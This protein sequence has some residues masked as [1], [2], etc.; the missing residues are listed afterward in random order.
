MAID[1]SPDNELQWVKEGRVFTATGPGDLTTP[2]DIEADLVVTTP[3]LLVRVPAGVVIVPLRFTFAAEA[4]GAA[5]FQL[6]LRSCDNDPGTAN[7]T[8]CTVVNANTRY[9]TMGSKCT[10]YHTS[11][12]A[13]TTPT[14]TADLLR[15]YIQVD[16]NAVTGTAHYDQ[17]VY[18]PL[19]GRGVPCVIGKNGNGTAFL[20][21]I[22]NATSGDGYGIA[23]WAEFTYDE[24]YA[25]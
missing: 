11:T 16:I 3:D 1:L 18:S 8:A 6:L 19:Q 20:A 12:G 10:A 9:A 5:V 17:V 23:T 22:A 24:F 13:C 2:G 7:R 25:T 21:Y 14:N 4:T 15:V